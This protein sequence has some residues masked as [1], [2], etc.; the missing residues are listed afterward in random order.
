M[1]NL[2][3]N[4]SNKA[5]PKKRVFKT[6]RMKGRSLDVTMR[7]LKV[8]LSRP[9]LSCHVSYHA[10]GDEI[11]TAHNIAESEDPQT[12]HSFDHENLM[13]VPT[14]EN[15]FLKFLADGIRL[16]VWTAVPFSP[17]TLP[18]PIFYKLYSRRINVHIKK[19]SGRTVTISALTGQPVYRLKTRLQGESDVDA[20]ANDL[21]LMY[22]GE[23]LADDKTL[24]DEGIDADVTLILSIQSNRKP[25]DS[26][27]SHSHQSN[28]NDFSILIN[29]P[30]PDSMD[31][32]ERQNKQLKNALRD[33]QA[34]ILDLERIGRSPSS[35]SSHGR[36]NLIAHR[37]KGG[38]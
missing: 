17:Q 20:P 38:L 33:A 13:T 24:A 9:V 16:R 1:Q 29:S 27:R 11:K 34:R 36:R 8:R 32:L 5:N 6:S 28:N 18:Q 26:I 35:N 2:L 22:R 23:E 12:L 15:V 10:V 7:I 4:E 37:K 3:S 21:I 19:P 25:K 31:G 14:C 30:M